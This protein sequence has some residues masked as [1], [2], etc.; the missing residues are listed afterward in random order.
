MEHI[1]YAYTHGMDD[2]EITER[3]RAKGTGVLSLAD[4]GDAYGIPL[5]HY[6]DGE[7]LYFRLG[8]TEDSRKRELLDGGGIV[9]YV[10]YGAEETEDP[11]SIDSWSIVA[12]GTL[13]RI[14]ESDHDSFDTAE[15][16]RH[17]SPIRVFDEDIEEIDIVIVRLDADSMTGRR[18]SFD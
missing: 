10:V 14:P 17:F 11:R 6:Y 7:D 8:M 3:L 12:E 4:D 1:E 16:N 5:A 18:T 15:I 13:T 9:S 2:E